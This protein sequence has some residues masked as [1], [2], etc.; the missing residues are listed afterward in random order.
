MPASGFAVRG[1]LRSLRDG[2]EDISEAFYYEGRTKDVTSREDPLDVTIHHS[3]TTSIVGMAA[4][5]CTK[6][7]PTHICFHKKQ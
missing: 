1:T 3:I 7:V 6:H 2:T 4:P 5:G